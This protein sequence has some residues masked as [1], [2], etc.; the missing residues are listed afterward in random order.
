MMRGLALV[1]SFLL[2][3]AIP[4]LAQTHSYPHD[5]SHPHDPSGHPPVDPA[6][7]AAIH[8]LLFGSWQ[9]TL[10]SSQGAASGLAMSIAHDSLRK[11]TLTMSADQPVQVGA[12][13]NLVINGDELTWTQ[14][15]AGASC[16]ATAVLTA[17]TESVPKMMKGKMACDHGEFSFNLR[18]TSG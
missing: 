13:S 17:A 12:A 18:K 1:A 9:G 10:N 14:D 16:Q 8:A 11:V 15:L 5:P 7:H 4:A 3:G 6:L 2:A